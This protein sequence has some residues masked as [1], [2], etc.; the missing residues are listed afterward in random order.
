MAEKEEER[1]SETKIE[2]EKRTLLL[3][4]SFFFSLSPP[5]SHALYLSFFINPHILKMV[6]KVW[7]RKKCRVR[8]V[9]RESTKEVFA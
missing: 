6:V 7:L 9:G 1:K 3:S 2:V 8:V 4:L 5:T